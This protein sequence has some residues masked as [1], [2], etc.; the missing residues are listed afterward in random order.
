MTIHSAIKTKGLARGKW[1]FTVR[2]EDVCGV[3]ADMARAAPG[4]LAPCEVLKLGQH[5][6][7]Q[8]ADRRVSNGSCSMPSAMASSRST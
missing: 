5:K 8:L 3:R 1:A 2:R 6:T 7:I 4:D